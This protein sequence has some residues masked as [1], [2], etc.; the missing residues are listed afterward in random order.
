MDLVSGLGDEVASAHNDFIA[1]WMGWT[2]LM[3]VI[4]WS[5]RMFSGSYAEEWL[6]LNSGYLL[7][8]IGNLREDAV[9]LSVNRLIIDM[10][11]LRSHSANSSLSRANSMSE[12]DLCTLAFF[13]TSLAVLKRLATPPITSSARAA[14]FDRLRQHRFS[15]K[16]PPEEQPHIHSHTHSK[17]CDS[18]ED[19]L[20]DQDLDGRSDQANDHRCI[21]GQF[22]IGFYGRLHSAEEDTN[23]N[24]LGAIDRFD[25]KKQLI[26]DRVQ[27]AIHHPTT[28][29]SLNALQNIPLGHTTMVKNLSENDRPIGADLA[30]RRKISRADRA[31][32]L[33][34]FYE[35][36]L[37]KVGRTSDM[38]RRMA[39]WDATCPVKGRR[40]PQNTWSIF[41]L[42]PNACLDRV[43]DVAIIGGR[44]HREKFKLRSGD[45]QLIYK[46]LIVPPKSVIEEV[47]EH[48]HV[49]YSDE[50]QHVSQLNGISTHS[51]FVDYLMGISY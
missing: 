7:D 13:S 1:A 33:Y 50:A 14:H 40:R 17:I 49:L 38:Q 31:G 32:W 4:K 9:T 22:I 35:N 25:F 20:R 11:S 26:I 18:E 42:K 8:F 30:L 6:K 3:G 45:P 2:R 48:T 44:V 21:R 34:V 51:P 28:S 47:A 43:I 41:Y 23:P 12:Q 46:E 15:H 29:D 5:S 27:E 37:F 19:D 10:I 24:S 16:I 36:G 39:E